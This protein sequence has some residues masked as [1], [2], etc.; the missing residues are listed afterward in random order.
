MSALQSGGSSK[1]IY[2]DQEKWS[3]PLADVIAAGVARVVCA[4]GDRHET[5]ADVRRPRP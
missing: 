1:T 4:I 5:A 2:F 3:F